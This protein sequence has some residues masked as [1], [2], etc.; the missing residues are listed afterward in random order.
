MYDLILKGGTVVDGTGNDPRKAN[1][2]ISNGKIAAITTEDVCGSEMLDVTGLVVAPGFIDIH[3]HSDAQP[4]T[5]VAPENNLLQGVTTEVVGNCG[6]AMIP[7]FSR[8]PGE[9]NDYS[10]S[11]RKHPGFES[12][13]QYLSELEAIKPHCNYATLAGHAN[14]RS[15]VLGYADRIPTEEEMEFMCKTLDYEMANGCFGMSLGLIYPPSSFAEK[16]ELVALAKVIAKYDGILSVHMRNEGPKLFEAVDEMIDIAEKS[17]VHIEISHLKLMG[18]PQWGRSPELLEKLES[19][20]ARGLNITC[21]Q[22]PFLASSTS[23][24]ALVPHWAHEGGKASLVQR[25]KDDDG[26]ILADM[27]KEM[28]NRGGSDA[29]LLVST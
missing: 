11:K 1:V 28:E 8:I 20:R 19:A 10:L 25:L 6:T 29:V 3:T 9:V 24:S 23:L 22:Y 14:L 4:F 27:Q 15:S 7:T 2:C 16:E 13:T 12:V 26:S 5:G 18:K 17:G 21:D